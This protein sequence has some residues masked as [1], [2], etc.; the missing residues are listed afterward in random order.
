MKINYRG[1]RDP[2]GQQHPRVR[3]RSPKL[4]H[5]RNYIGKDCLSGQQTEE[6]RDRPT[7]QEPRITRNLCR[8]NSELPSRHKA[9]EEEI[10]QIGSR[11]ALRA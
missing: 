9:V 2:R 8:W 11:T 1:N 10:G 7:V 3:R 6:R 4:D 5:P